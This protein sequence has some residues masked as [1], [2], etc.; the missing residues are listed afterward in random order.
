MKNRCC[1]RAL[2]RK[3]DI[4]LCRNAVVFQLL[5][6]PLQF[7]CADWPLHYLPNS[8]AGVVECLLRG[9]QVVVHNRCYHLPMQPAVCRVTKNDKEH[10]GTGAAVSTTMQPSYRVYFP[11]AQ[12]SRGECGP[13]CQ[14]HIAHLESHMTCR[15]DHKSK[16]LLHDLVSE[17]GQWN[18]RCTGRHDTDRCSADQPHLVVV[19]PSVRV[20]SAAA[21]KCTCSDVKTNSFINRIQQ[22]TGQSLSSNPR[23]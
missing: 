4:F 1:Q 3:Y 14:L 18:H 10:R 11:T 21:A 6:S 13:T 17:C 23:C 7:R 15:D 2:R 9:R 20:H 16:N 22:W 19:R 12:W 5:Y 8:S